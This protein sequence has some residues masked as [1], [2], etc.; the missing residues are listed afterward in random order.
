MRNVTP[1][2]AP[3]LTAGPDFAPIASGSAALLDPTDAI[4]SHVLLSLHLGVM[5]VA[6]NY[7]VCTI[8]RSL[9]KTLCFESDPVQSSFLDLWDESPRAVEHLVRKTVQ[10]SKPRPFSLHRNIGG[11]RQQ[12]TLH[13]YTL[14]M[15]HNGQRLPR[16]IVI[17]HEGETR[18]FAELRNIYKLLQKERARSLRAEHALLRL[19]ESAKQLNR[20]LHHRVRNNLAVLAAMVRHERR[21]AHPIAHAPLL[22]TEHRIHAMGDVQ[23]AFDT[24]SREDEPQNIYVHIVV[25]AITERFR[26]LLS[27]FDITLSC[28]I[29]PVV[30]SVD[31]ATPLA[32]FVSEAI[33]KAQEIVMARK[34]NRQ[35]HVSVRED[36]GGTV[37]ARVTTTGPLPDHVTAAIDERLLRNL[38]LQ[39]GTESTTANTLPEQ[40]D[41]PD[42]SFG[43][44]FKPTPLQ[45]AGFAAPAPPSAATH[46]ALTTEAA[47]QS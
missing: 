4:H 47:P 3:P 31:Q 8:N 18:R 22:R 23:K 33:L 6:R 12:F 38:M 27:A 17:L 37:T 32:L 24:T 9:A 11:E 44:A 7:D 39:L 29:S 2:R 34:T 36:D 45:R 28:E 30:L 35:I 13:G 42:L 19:L 46:P 21:E 10:T 15:D 41:T 43:V 14:A 20:E 25:D 26:K 40:D 1:P 16:Y 5:V